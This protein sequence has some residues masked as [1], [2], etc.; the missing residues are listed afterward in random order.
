[1]SSSPSLPWIG[2]ERL[3]VVAAT[4]RSGKPSLPRAFVDLLR[5]SSTSLPWIITDHKA[6][7]CRGSTRSRGASLS[8]IVEE[9]RANG[10]VAPDA[11]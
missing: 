3:V 10:P 4:P 11:I 7:D 8:W 5:S 2:W 1:M 9:Q 6:I